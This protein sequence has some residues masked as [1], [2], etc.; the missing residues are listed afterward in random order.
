VTE[1]RPTLR[2]IASADDMSLP[3]MWP[4]FDSLAARHDVDCSLHLLGD[5][6][7]DPE[8]I[9]VRSYVHSHLPRARVIGEV[10]LLRGLDVITARCRSVHCALS[11]H[12]AHALARTSRSDVRS[13]K[14]AAQGADTD[15][16]DIAAVDLQALQRKRDARDW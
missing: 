14:L 2:V 12:T 9:R 11:P 16:E 1:T 10:W 8:F 7:G 5:Y 15:P 6:S 13:H 4:F 3:R